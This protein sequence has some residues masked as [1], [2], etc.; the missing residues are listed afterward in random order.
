MAEGKIGCYGVSSNTLP[1]DPEDC[2]ST[3]LSR[4]IQA[5]EEAGGAEHNFRVVQFPFNLLESSATEGLLEL[6]QKHRIGVL[7][8]RSLNGFVGQ[9]LVRLADF[10]TEDEPI[11]FKENL[12]KLQELETEYRATFGE[13]VQGPGADQLFRFSEHLVELPEHLENLEHWTQIESSRIRPTLQ[14]QIGAL[15]QAMAGPI[16]AAWVDWRDRYSA[17]FRELVNDLE[18][19]AA[20]KSQSLS[21][22]VRE[23]IQADI[24]AEH[25]EQPLSRLALWAVTST[26][27]ITSAL[28]GMRRPDY[29]EDALEVLDWTLLDNVGKIYR[30]LATW[31][32]GPPVLA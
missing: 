27:G 31:Q 21:D 11:Y 7:T 2:D 26:P 28:V 15:N 16:A 4:F 32:P 9:T 30:D 23:Q 24:P 19:L 1:N 13:V 5:A 18:E 8:N 12:A 22:S 3:S 20:R 10:E 25:R 29:V 17:Q 6:A 14:E